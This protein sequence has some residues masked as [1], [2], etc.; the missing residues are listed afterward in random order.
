[1]FITITSFPRSF[2]H[3]NRSN[4][5]RSKTNSNRPIGVSL[6]QGQ[7]EKESALLRRC[8]SHR[9]KR[10]KTSCTFRDGSCSHVRKNRHNYSK[11]IFSI[12]FLMSKCEKNDFAL[13]LL[14]EAIKS[15]E[16]YRFQSPISIDLN[17][18][19]KIRRGLVI[20]V[21]REKE[22]ERSIFLDSLRL[23]LVETR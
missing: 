17:R 4:E 6:R 19:E 13:L 7:I 8:G 12:I 11:I 18:A 20:G 9:E 10:R 21:K 22:S 16:L 15:S 5:T 1:M 3:I 23:E 2:I 14:S